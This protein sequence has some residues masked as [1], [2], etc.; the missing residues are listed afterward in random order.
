MVNEKNSINVNNCFL[1]EY[2]LME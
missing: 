2:F 1:K